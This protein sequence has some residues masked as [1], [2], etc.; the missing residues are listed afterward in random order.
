LGNEGEESYELELPGLCSV[1]LPPD[2][3]DV[4][5]EP[6]PVPEAAERIAVLTAADLGGDERRFG[7]RGSPTR[8]LAVRDVTPERARELFSDPAEA[9]ARVRELLAERPRRRPPGRSRNG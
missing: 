5:V 9:A 3:A 6:L 8:V 7:Q 1:A 2:G 4:D